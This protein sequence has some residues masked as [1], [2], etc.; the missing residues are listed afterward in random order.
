MT[1]LGPYVQI[2]QR[3]RVVRREV[4][5]TQRE[6]ERPRQGK[7]GD[8]G[9]FLDDPDAAYGS[10]PGPTLVTFRADELVDV[11]ALLA[12]GAIREPRADQLPRAKPKRQRTPRPR[13][14][15]QA[16][17]VAPVTPDEEATSEPHRST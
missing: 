17:P 5:H 8:W 1:N 7:P 15:P 12:S 10:K 14:P 11:P 9:D 6:C 3:L 13:K 2:T 16:A 4:P